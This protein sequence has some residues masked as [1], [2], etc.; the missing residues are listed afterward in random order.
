MKKIDIDREWELLKGEPSGIPGMPQE[1]KTVNLPHDYIVETDVS[2]GSKNGANTG[3]YNGGTMTY[4]KYLDIPKEWTEKRVLVSFDGCF[5]QTKVVVNGHVA[6]RHHYGYTPFQTDITPYLKFGMKNRLSVTA[7][8]DAEPNSRW[9]SGGGLYRHVKLL[10]APKVHLAPC[11]IF[12]HLDHLVNGDAFVVVETTV[13]NHTAEDVSVWVKLDIFEDGNTDQSAGGGKIKVYVPAGQNGTARTQ[14][15]IENAKIWDVDSPD[16]YRI[17]A[18]LT[19]GEE[20]LDETDALFG[21]R[22]ISMDA[23]NGFMLNG[24]SLKLKGGC[25]HHDNGILGAV[26]LYDSEYRKVK[27]HKQNGYNALRF[28]HNPVSGDMLEACDRLGVVVI[29]E[30]FDTWNMQKNYFDFSQFFAAEGMEE[31]EAALLRDR[32]HPSVIMW[33]IGNELPEQGGLSKGYQVSAKLADRVRQLDNTRFVAGALCS[34]FSGLDDE[35]TGKFWQSLMQSAAQNGGAVSNLDGEYGRGIW[36]EYTEGFCAPWDVV[37]YNYLNYQYEAA[38]TRFPNRVIACTESKPLQME[39]YW[40]D[41]EKYPYLIGDFVWTSQ[42]YIGEAGIGKVLHVKPGEEAAAAGRMHFAAYPWR[43]S[44]GGDFD[45]CGFEKPQLAYRRILWGSKETFI[46]VK[47]P[48]F[49]GM[50]ELLDRYGWTDAAN[51]W[52]WAIEEN[53]PIQAEVY[54]SAEEVELFLNGQSLGR[55]P[56]GRDNH[57]KALFDLTYVK[58]TLEAVS[59]ADGKEISRNTLHSAKEPAGLRIVPDEKAPHQTRL[60]ADGQ[61]LCFAVIEVVDADGNAV[62]YVEKK[63]VARMEGAAVL[64]AFGT[65]R[66][67]TEENYTRGEVTSYKGRI[68][69]VIRSGYDAGKAVLTVKMEGLPEA[70]LELEIL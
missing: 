48:A 42:D 12:A 55:K 5:G 40:R 17:T 25:I 23:K 41:V 26:S 67:V 6:G 52:T 44:G 22:T 57:N 7:A 38:G 4:T 60:R 33:S 66:P 36:N 27:I 3:F 47:N 45:L 30:I 32:N 10:V 31:L 21:V 62:P 54:S 19:D 56:A 51:T 37:G 14:L 61:S 2:A 39:E 24:R 1:K 68:L 46:A 63:A 53:R 58:G 65:G 43:T 29:D 64:A 34:F 9:Y 20:V 35:D 49:Y 15:M 70:K 16:L 11:A 50:T 28:A 8:T 18:A 59:Y 69:A 13:E